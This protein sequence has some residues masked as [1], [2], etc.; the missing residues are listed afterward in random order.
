MMMGNRLCWCRVVAAAAVFFLAGLTPLF[1]AG[2]AENLPEERE[3]IE[4]LVAEAAEERFEDE[5]E[6][7]AFHREVLAELSEEFVDVRGLEIALRASALREEPASGS[8]LAAWVVEQHTRAERRLARGESPHRVTAQLGFE[9][10]AEVPEHAARA[11]ERRE[12]A[13]EIRERAEERARRIQSGVPGPQD[14]PDGVP[15]GGPS[16]TR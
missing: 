7:E 11:A 5:N 9:A 12:R 4:A 13:A 14:A 2:A 15:G 16:T 3:Q 10:R 8:E 1:A 6:R